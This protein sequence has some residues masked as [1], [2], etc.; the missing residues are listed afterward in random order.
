[1]LAASNEVDE[2]KGTSGN[3]I[4]LSRYPTASFPSGKVDNSDKND[5]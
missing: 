3:N 1:M 4:S 5:N 2:E